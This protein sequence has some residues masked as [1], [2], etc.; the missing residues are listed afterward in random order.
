MYI[1]AYVHAQPSSGF[2]GLPSLDVGTL[3]LRGYHRVSLPPNTLTWLMFLCSGLRQLGYMPESAGFTRQKS[4]KRSRSS[5]RV[6]HAAI[7][8]APHTL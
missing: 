5:Y 3:F 7:S 2:M 8:R 4:K 1:T 6:P